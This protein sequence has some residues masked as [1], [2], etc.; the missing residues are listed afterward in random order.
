MRRVA[1]PA[2]LVVLALTAVFARQAPVASPVKPL[3]TP[4]APPVVSVNQRVAIPAW[5]FAERAMLASAAEGVQLWV[6]R[7]VNA[8]GSL[9]IPER[10]GVSD[11]PDDI[12]EGIR[13]WPLVYA[14]GA[15][16]SVIR[17]FERVWEGHLRQFGRARLPAIELA[18]DGIFVKEFPS[19][20]D[21]EHNGEGLQAF[22]W[23]GLGK[24]AD[25]V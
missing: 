5:A 16:E 19:S 8:D 7:Y 18:K 10:W 4:A 11:G 3:A 13:G 21:W 2:I 12:T 23:Y 15:P 22:Y 20:F 25:P 17:N 24:P 9:N 1:V 6:D 14:M